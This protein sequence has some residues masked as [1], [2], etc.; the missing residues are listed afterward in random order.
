MLIRMEKRVSVTVDICWCT[1]EVY[2]QKKKKKQQQLG[3]HL[4]S[5]K[6]TWKQSAQ[7]LPDK[8]SRWALIMYSKEI[9]KSIDIKAS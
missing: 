5:R 1:L 3:S 2:N 8:A 7:D 4:M 9:L 6:M